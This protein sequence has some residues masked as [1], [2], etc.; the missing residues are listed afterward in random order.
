M[1]IQ[2]EVMGAVVTGAITLAFART[3]V[4]P[5]EVVLSHP[6]HWLLCAQ[7]IFFAVALPLSTVMVVVT[8]C[9]REESS[10]LWPTLYALDRCHVVFHAD[11]SGGIL[12]DLARDCPIPWMT[13]DYRHGIIV[14]RGA[15]ASP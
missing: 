15:P 3:R 4:R 14:G 1:T 7:A 10:S 11:W 5:G 12:D 6:G 9:F 8:F 13:L 2:I